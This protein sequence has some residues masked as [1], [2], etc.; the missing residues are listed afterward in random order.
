MDQLVANPT[1][2]ANLD[3][4][5]DQRIYHYAQ[6]NTPV[7]GLPGRIVSLGRDSA[8]GLQVRVATSNCCSSGRSLGFIA[9]FVIL[10]IRLYCM[11]CRQATETSGAH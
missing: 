6:V 2:K 4:M 7:K 9:H 10:N 11:E 1:T 5:W 3:A 8:R